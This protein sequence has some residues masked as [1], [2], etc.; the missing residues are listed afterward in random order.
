VPDEQTSTINLPAAF[1]RR[2]W[3]AAAVFA[4]ALTAAGGALYSLPNLY[5]ATA[6]VF[7]QREEVSTAFVRSAVTSEVDARIQAISQ[8]LL[9]RARLEALLEQ[10]NLYAAYRG[11][12]TIEALVKRLRSD[13]TVTSLSGNAARPET[14]AFS[15][16]YIGLDPQTVANVANSLATSYI[17]EN[18][19]MREG[20][21]KGTAGFLKARLDEVKVRLDALDTQASALR[22]RYGAELP[23]QTMVNLAVLDRLNA[24]LRFIN[25]KQQ[26]ALDRRDALRAEAQAAARMGDTAGLPPT[27]SETSPGAR[28]LIGLTNELT[29]LLARFGRQHPDVRRVQREIAALEASEPA[30]STGSDVA[31]AP[32]PPG[33]ASAAKRAGA[34]LSG[35]D[36]ELLRLQEDEKALRAQIA[37]YERR[38]EGAPQRAQAIKESSRDY[39]ATVELYDSLLKRYEDARLS[40]NVETQRTGDQFRI[41]DAAIPPTMHM[42]PS[43]IPLFLIAMLLSAALA[44]GAVLVREQFDTS[45]HTLDDLRR[46]THVRVVGS[47]PPIVSPRDRVRQRW[48]VAV[49]LTG[50]AGVLALILLSSRLLAEDNVSLVRLLARGK[51]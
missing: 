32:A 18:L 21:A 49:G 33:P 51:V 36:Q 26:R 38:I 37:S 48:Q 6:T 44:A 50:S 14:T 11:R 25:D 9:S 47:I 1:W 28:R 27:S 19:Q 34:V 39:G 41:L 16:S 7:V 31:S 17:A 3:L 45:I 12:V 23:E 46:F 4:G 35:V 40:E 13:I 24:E 15:L 2:R 22:A 10:H 20:Q 30:D 8:S 42:A 29:Q 5:R 43:R